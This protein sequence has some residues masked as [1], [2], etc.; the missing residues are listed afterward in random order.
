MKIDPPRSNRVSLQEP[1]EASAT[2]FQRLRNNTTQ[3][4]SKH[5]PLP[6]LQVGQEITAIVVRELAD[7]RITLNLNGALIEANN[8]GGL[9]AGETLRLRV[10]LLDPEIILQIIERELAPEEEAVRLLR[11][12]LGGGS[13]AGRDSLLTLQDKLA[14]QPDTRDGGR[15]HLR[16]DKLRDFITAFLSK[17]E[18]LTSQRL[19]EMVRDCGLH[20]ESKLFRVVAQNPQRLAEI[21]DSDLKGLLL[22]ALKELETAALTGEP[23]NAILGQ[24]N[25][26]EG[27]QAVNLL[28]QMKGHA[29]QLY[30]PLFSGDSLFTVALS[31][32]RDGKG[33]GTPTTAKPHGYRIL[34]LLDLEHFGHTRIDSHVSADDLTVIFYVDQ[35]NSVALLKRELP[36]FRETL[37]FM[38]Y[39]D[40]WLAARG[41]NAM[42]Q[43]QQSQ[44]N[45]LALGIPPSLSL[46]DVKA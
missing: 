3:S 10:E 20:Y 7:G 31:V 45:A 5:A 8:L 27:H 39:R 35:E 29:F 28:A 22:G 18:P 24:L 37:K 30:L 13:V 14:V 19:A 26:L 9:A 36:R 33:A 23:R 1:Q 16:L 43:D 40:V 34:F 21:A 4:Q 42:S 17:G 44:F 32:E 6:P 11:Q 12:Q 38:G 41:M 46:L 15:T 2:S 25:T